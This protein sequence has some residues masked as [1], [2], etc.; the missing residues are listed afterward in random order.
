MK[1]RYDPPVGH[2]GFWHDEEWVHFHWAANKIGDKLA[3]APGAAQARLRRL[4]ESGEIRSLMSWDEEEPETI[5]PTQW[6]EEDVDLTWRLT[7]AVSRNDLDRWLDQQPVQPTAGGKQSR[8]YRLL[9]D[10]FPTGVPHRADRPREQLKAELL[11]RDPSLAPLDLKT[12][13]TAIDTYNRQLGNARNASV[14][15]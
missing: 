1:L 10:M 4:C 6:R 8:I 9:S 5:S 11:K 15:D 7:V 2:C 12:L 13:K 3:I 14:S